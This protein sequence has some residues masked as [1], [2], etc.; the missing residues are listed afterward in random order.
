MWIGCNYHFPDSWQVDS[1]DIRTT[2]TPDDCP[3]CCG[4]TWLCRGDIQSEVRALQLAV[5]TTYTQNSVKFP[6]TGDVVISVI[7]SRGTRSR[8]SLNGL[9]IHI[10]PGQPGA[11]SILHELGA[12]TARGFLEPRY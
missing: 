9:I 1:K 10:A 2:P 6:I 5:V 7:A 11:R 12:E 4:P 8:R 3:C